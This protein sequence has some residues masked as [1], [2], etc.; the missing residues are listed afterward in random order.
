MVELLTSSVSS[1][2]SNGVV[3]PPC[4][5]CPCACA[6]HLSIV[7]LPHLVKTSPDTPS[8]NDLRRTQYTTQYSVIN[9]ETA[10]IDQRRSRAL[11]GLCAVHSDLHMSHVLTLNLEKFWYDLRIR[12]FCWPRSFEHKKDESTYTT[13]Y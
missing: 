6:A 13:P 3:L 1:C 11:R 10:P 5:G 7:V 8:P 4:I 2:S 9:A 12:D